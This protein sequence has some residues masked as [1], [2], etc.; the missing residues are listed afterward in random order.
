MELAMAIEANADEIASIE[1]Q[2]NGKAYSIA[3]GF[4]VSEAAACLRYY[5]GWADK[6]HGK[7]NNLSL[8]ISLLLCLS[9]FFYNDDVDTNQLPCFDRLS[10][11]IHLNSLIL[12][13]ILSVLSVKSSLGI[14]LSSCLHGNLVQPSLL[15]T[16]SFSKLL[17]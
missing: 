13:I 1:S 2:D 7:V 11:L 10:K 8:V 6:H 16:P 12:P 17:K 4:D 15:V 3:R 5:G 14:S 9:L